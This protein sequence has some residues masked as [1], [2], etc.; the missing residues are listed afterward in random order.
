MLKS[1]LTLT[2][3]IEHEE[4]LAF[5]ASGIAGEVAKMLRDIAEGEEKATPGI[6]IK[7]G[8]Y[9]DRDHLSGPVM[10]RVQSAF[11]AS[12]PKAKEARA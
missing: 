11:M 1:E 2:I 8:T 10:V 12:T 9:Y 6:V 3:F 7:P 4:P 5:D